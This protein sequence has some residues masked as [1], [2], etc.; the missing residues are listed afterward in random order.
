[1]LAD[2]RDFA[3]QDG[4]P[5]LELGHGQRIEVLFGQERDRIAGAREI[6]FGIHDAER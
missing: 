6:L 3:F 2:T 1:M 4:D 5:L